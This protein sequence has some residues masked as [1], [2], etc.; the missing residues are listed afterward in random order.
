MEQS[1]RE[2]IHM[3][4][5]ITLSKSTCPKTQDERTHMSMITYAST[6]GSIMYTMLYTRPYVSYAF[7]VTSIYQSDLGEGHWVVV[8]NIL[9]YLRRTKDLFLICG[10]S[11]LIVSRYTDSN[12]QSDRDDFKSQSGYV[13]MLNGGVVSWKSSK[14]DTIVDSTI[15]SEYIAA[16]KSAKEVVWIRKFIDELEVVPSIVDPI[17]LYCDNNGA[18]QEKETPSHQR[19][20]YVLRRYHLIREIIGRHNVIIEKVPTDQNAISVK[21]NH[22]TK[23]SLTLMSSPMV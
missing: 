12:F 20:K 9:K 23:Q 21:A 14:Q 15:E 11:D 17:P 10:D 5:R 7:S 3:T 16:S 18:T 22:F 19:S 2:Y 13:F 6:I 4:H 1:K 8:K